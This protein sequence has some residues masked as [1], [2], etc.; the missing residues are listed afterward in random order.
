[1]KVGLFIGRFQP[2]HRGHLLMIKKLA[3]TVDRLIIGLGSSNAEVSCRNPFSVPERKEMISRVMKEIGHR[4]Y[5]IVELLDIK[6]DEEWIKTLQKTVGKFDISWSGS[7]WVLRVFK[8]HG[9]PI[10][11]IKE[12]PGLSGTKI[13]KKMAQGLPWLKFVPSS[14]RKYLREIGVVKRVREL[15]LGSVRTTGKKV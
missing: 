8:A 6:S 1:M 12:F 15:C 2:L 3:A 7:E 14:V 9:L 11:R 13:R 10:D 5:E 4:H